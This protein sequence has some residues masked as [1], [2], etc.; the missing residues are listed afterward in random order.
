MIALRTTRLVPGMIIM[1]EL[2]DDNQ[3][4]IQNVVTKEESSMNK[5]N[6]NVICEET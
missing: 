4:G 2:R 5:L 1:E 3:H 6:Y